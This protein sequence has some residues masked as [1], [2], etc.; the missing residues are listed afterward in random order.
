MHPGMMR[1]GGCL[2]QLMSLAGL[3]LL[4]SLVLTPM[5]NEVYWFIVFVS[6][7]VLGALGLLVVLYLL[8]FFRD[9]LKAA[10]AYLV[11]R[12]QNAADRH[13]RW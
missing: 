8:W 5:L 7:Y 3:L 11:E 9:A 1:G 10:A 2:G 12:I 4:L 6:P 13:R